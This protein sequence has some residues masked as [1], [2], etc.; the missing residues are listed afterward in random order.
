LSDLPH[1]ESSGKNQGEY[2]AKLFAEGS[3]IFADNALLSQKALADKLFERTGQSDFLAPPS[4]MTVE[5]LE[6]AVREVVPFIISGYD[7]AQENGASNKATISAASIIGARATIDELIPGLKED[8]TRAYEPAFVGA[9]ATLHEDDVATFQRLRLRLKD[10]GVKVSSW[11]SAVKKV[12]RERA[13]ESKAAQAQIASKTGKAAKAQQP[14]PTPLAAQP[15]DGAC[16]VEDLIKA[17][18]DHVILANPAAALITALWII[19]TWCFRAANFSPRIAVTSPLPRCGKTVY[20]KVLSA[21]ACRPFRLSN[22]SPAVVYR[23]IEM[24]HPTLLLM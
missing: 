20:L 13:A 10:K 9:A 4:D 8:I 18:N 23:K 1:D 11:E 15:V 21:L 14:P 12:V 19:H 2:K 17:V 5:E 3:V 24:E 7:A 22:T 6:N 16:L